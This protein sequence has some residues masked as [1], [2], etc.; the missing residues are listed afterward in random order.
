MLVEG[1]ADGILD[2]LWDGDFEGLSVDLDED[3]FD[4][5]GVADVGLDDEGLFV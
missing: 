4:V 3:G 5:E 2:G 1:R